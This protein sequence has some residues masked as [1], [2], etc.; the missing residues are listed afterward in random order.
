MAQ[1][2]FPHIS[3]YESLS[4]A[5]YG[6]FMVY[7]NPNYAYARP[8]PHP[9]CFVGPVLQVVQA[10]DFSAVSTSSGWVST[11]LAALNADTANKP[12]N[13]VANYFPGASYWGSPQAVK[14]AFD[15]FTQSVM[16]AY[17][18][19]PPSGGGGGGGGS[20]DWTTA[21]IDALIQKVDNISIS[22]EV[23]VLLGGS[24]F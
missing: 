9:H 21:K 13:I 17:M 16:D 2:F 12:V 15:F 19:A 7:V 22:T 20:S 23:P 4:T 24:D 1:T 5:L 8:L 6:Y 18:V 3:F 10:A 11:F 14:F